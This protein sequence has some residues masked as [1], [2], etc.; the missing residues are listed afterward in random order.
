MSS[1]VRLLLATKVAQQVE[2]RVAS[3]AAFSA[4][5]PPV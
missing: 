1:D 4:Q 5:H 2:R 3:S